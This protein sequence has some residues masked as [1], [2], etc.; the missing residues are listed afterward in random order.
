MSALLQTLLATVQRVKR[1]GVLGV[2]VL[3]AEAVEHRL[4]LRAGHTRRSRPAESRRLQGR[5]WL[6]DGRSARFTLADADEITPRVL[7][8]AVRLATD[9]AADT[10]P[11]PHAGPA[12]RLGI[13]TRGLGL[14]DP[15]Y[16]QVGPEARAEVLSLNQDALDSGFRLEQATYTD[17]RTVR[18]YV[19]TRDVHATSGD[20]WFHVSL[21]VTDTTTGRRLSGASGARNFAHVASLPY[22]VD[23]ARRLT[24][25]RQSVAPPA[26]AVPLVFEARVLAT[27]IAALGPTFSAEACASGASFVPR[28]EGGVLA[29]HRVHLIDDAGLHGAPRTLPF[30]DE[31]VPGVPVTVISEGRRGGLLHDVRSARAADIRPTGHVRDGA[32]RAT[33]LVLRPGNRSRTQM[34]SE[35]PVSLAFDHLDGS[36]DPATGALAMAGPALVLHRGRPQGAVDRVSIRCNVVELLQRVQEVASDQERHGQVDCA[37]ALVRAMPVDNG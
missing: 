2:E 13:G 17:V 32:P 14:D 5:V 20:T 23:L 26:E 1:P 37:T 24:S 22:A 29:S 28:V 15:R 8:E 34:L 21:E 33:N 6:D 18:T 31:G 19:N 36:L 12:P 25:L 30:D 3:H 11:D 27:V 35:V 10:A 16:S 7:E 4:T 9:A